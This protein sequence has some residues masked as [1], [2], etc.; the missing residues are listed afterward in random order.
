MLNPIRVCGLAVAL[1][2]VP[3]AGAKE[4]PTKPVRM[5]IP[6]AAGGPTDVTGRI[7]GQSLTNQLGRQFV[8]VNKGG[9]SGSIGSI[10]AA[11][12]TPDGYTV[13]YTAS[14]FAL[15]PLLDSKLGYD[16]IRDYQP[17]SLTVTQPMAVVVNPRI[18]ASTVPEFIGY[19][20]ANQDKLTYGTTGAG[21]I[22]HLVVAEFAKR[23]DLRMI[24]VP[25]KGSSLVLTDLVGGQLSM[26]ISTFSTALPFV[27]AGR[28]R[29]LAISS[30]KRHP[31]LP[32]LP[33]L[34][35]AVGQEYQEFGTWHGMLAP[36][37]TPRPIVNRLHKE[38]SIALS[39]PNVRKTLV[40]QGSD[41]VGSTPEQFTL[42]LKDEMARWG[43]VVRDLGLKPLD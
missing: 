42:R 25:Y 10:E 43:Q 1:C 3:L 4:Y 9:A 31:L 17:I 28:L 12:A 27:R 7:L 26:S 11:M 32:E 2:V 39:D 14:S 36:K 21:G 19:A 8:I 34:T 22:T 5:I 18:P 33:T 24:H 41:P 29:A 15:A 16:P 13:M 40:A 23:F 30:A 6:F 37:A 35:E 20:R 38:I